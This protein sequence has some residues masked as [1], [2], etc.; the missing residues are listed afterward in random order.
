MAVGTDLAGIMVRLGAVAGETERPR[1][2][3]GSRRSLGMAVRAFGLMDVG[4][5]GI[6]GRSGVAGGALSRRGMM[7][8]MAFGAIGLGTLSAFRVAGIASQAGVAG[9]RER[10]VP[11][12][13]GVPNRERHRDGLGARKGK[14]LF[15][16]TGHARGCASTLVVTRGAVR[17]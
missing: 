10:Q 11:R 8:F 3:L 2:G 4:I 5:V 9:V 15:R 17:R 1:V 16:M 7:R 12:F 13:R 6:G 14:L